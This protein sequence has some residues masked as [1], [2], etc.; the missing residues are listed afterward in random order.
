MPET[1]FS[2]IGYN[3][4]RL[5]G[6]GGTARVFLATATNRDR[7]YALKTSLQTDAE[8]MTGFLSLIRREY[9]LIGGLTYPGLVRTV[10]LHESDACPPFLVIEYCPG[11][12]LDRLEKIESLSVLLN[13][14]SSVSINLYYLK[15]AGLAHGDLK[16]H[17]IFLADPADGYTDNR[18]L[19]SKISDFSLALKS[20]EPAANRLGVGTIGYLAPETINDNTLDHRSDIF[21]L[22]TI[23]YQLAT[24]YH[25]F[26]R[27]ETDPVRINA[28]VKEHHPAPP[29]EINGSLPDRLSR[30]IMTM[31]EKNSGDRP[32][33]GYAVC[34]EL[35]DIGAGYPFRRMIR[36][37]HVLET[38]PNSAN[39][40][41]LR[42]GAFSFQDKHIERILDYS[43]DD[44]IKLRSILEVN[45]TRKLLNW[46]GGR[47]T[48]ECRADQIVW[49]RKMQCQDRKRFH[50]L[51]YSAKKKVILTAVVG[52]FDE[53]ETLGIVSES[54]R[55]EYLSRPLVYFVRKNL[56]HLT[57][58]RFA[59][60]LADAALDKFLDEIV[61]ATLYLRAENLDKG[62]TVTLD[63]AN[64]LINENSYQRAFELLRLLENICREKN[65]DKKLAVTLMEIGDTEKMIGEASRAEK[66]YLQII[67]LYENRPPDKLLAETYKDLGDLYKMKQDYDSG[68]QVLKQAEKL[69]SELGD[70]LELSHTLN[71]MGN[72]YAV[73]GSLDE[74]IRYYLRALRIQRQLGATKDVAMILSNIAAI[75]YYRG[76]YARTLRLF[77]MA[78]RLQREVGNQAEIARTHNNLG[79]LLYEMGNFDTSLDHLNESI[80]LNRKIGLKKELL[81]NLDNLTLVMLHAGRLKESIQF[82]REGMTLSEELADRP[83]TA[84]FTAN[85]ASV[86]KRMGYYGQSIDKYRQALK[87]LNE[88][89]DSYNVAIATI[90]LADLY[91]RLNRL[92]DSQKL[93]N[94]MLRQ[95]EKTSDRK[96]AI[97][98]YLLRGKIMKD[99]HLIERA[100]ATAREISAV[101]AVNVGLLE[102]ARVLIAVGE[103]DRS[104][105]I[106]RDLSD[107]FAESNSDIE[108]ASFFILLGTL[109]LTA[110]EIS[111]AR[112]DFETAL[113]IAGK[114]GLLPELAE[115]AAKLGRINSDIKEYEASYQHYRKAIN[116]IKTIAD[117]IKDEALK[118]SFLSDGKI[119]SV[120]GEVK[121]LGQLL[122]QKKGADR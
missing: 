12:T 46:K 6:T 91:F 83:H 92:E 42:T 121:K 98:C 72:I 74:A 97:Q 99:A 119:A 63:A 71:N 28:A 14:I 39:G 77:K 66:T 68:I 102:L 53:A 23:A 85:L 3:I 57:I 103:I 44:P 110:G 29:V 30:L 4:S 25:P 37:K 86:Q 60:K 108:N 67:G 65:D 69:Y 120:A 118:Q 61:A 11:R 52:G 117:D 114:Y 27:D 87:I 7:Q 56:S 75:S 10:K 55:Q 106:L 78:L 31:L 82:I 122:A 22:G 26:L 9:Q 109:H 48:F 54:A 49:P 105:R 50:R 93:I 40:E 32:D 33:N 73:R 84:S 81:I 94:E 13:V 1:S 89:N 18:F 5:L 96:T 64:K 104:G 112:T 101:R 19:Y 107:T 17:N 70:R 115:A 35:E 62:Y 51:P 8:S 38:P 24:G 2:P 21:S 59:N 80:A 41:V 113:R 116:T 76:E 20:D 100:T 43:G 58:V 15:L 79:L 47:L 45:F 95:A 90:G 88:I 36:P 34:M 111:R 16:P